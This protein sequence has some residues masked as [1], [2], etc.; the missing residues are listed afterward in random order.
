MMGNVQD[1]Q[2]Q[3]QLETPQDQLSK[4]VEGLWSSDLIMAHHTALGSG[5]ELFPKAWVF[6][7]RSFL[8]FCFE[9]F[10]VCYTF[11]SDLDCEPSNSKLVGRM[12]WKAFIPIPPLL[13]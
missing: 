7:I 2:Q 11:L 4:F 8:L 5:E 1:Q 9:F 6:S 13:S 10:S 3:Q 12:L